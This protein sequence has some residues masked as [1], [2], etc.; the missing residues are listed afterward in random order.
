MGLKDHH[1]S[2]LA[3]TARVLSKR[4]GRRVSQDDV[5]CILLDLAIQDEG[6]YDPEDPGRPVDP[7]R[8]QIMQ[9]ETSARGTRLLPLQAVEAILALSDRSDA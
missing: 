5:L 2:Y 3:R 8:R 1:R 7:L 6:T 9:A 4:L